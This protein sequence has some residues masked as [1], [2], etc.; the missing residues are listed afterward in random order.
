MDAA[1]ALIG[2]ASYECAVL[3]KGN[4]NY[5]VGGSIIFIRLPSVERYSSVDNLQ[6][7]L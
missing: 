7:S 1:I 2:T 3:L 4:Q 6:D 5:E